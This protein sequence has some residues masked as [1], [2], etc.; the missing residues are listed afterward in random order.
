[1]LV[2]VRRRPAEEFSFALA[3]ILTPPVIAREA[4]RLYREHAPLAARLDVG[5]LAGPGLVGMACSFVAGL[6]ALR[7]LSRW[8]ENGRWHYFGFYCLAAA[9]GVCALSKMGY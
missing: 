8:L 2:G 7:W 5:A 3:V 1:M 6:V 9:A 4:W